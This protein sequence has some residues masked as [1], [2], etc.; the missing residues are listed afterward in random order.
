VWR[1][2]H[3][4]DTILFT[5]FLLFAQKKEAN[6]PA[7]RQGKGQPNPNAPLDLARLTHK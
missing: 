5:F 7:G 1:F 3:N 2:G 6:L 4:L